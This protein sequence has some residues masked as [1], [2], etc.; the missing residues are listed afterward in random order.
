MFLSIDRKLIILL[1]FLGYDPN[2][3]ADWMYSKKFMMSKCARKRLSCYV[4]SVKPAI[5]HYVCEM[6]KTFTKAGQRMVR[7]EFICLY[8]YL[9]T[10]SIIVYNY[11]S[12]ECL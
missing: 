8:V 1:L 11:K 4:R 5:R 9:P 12:V 7:S 6:N 3:E 10:L 2:S